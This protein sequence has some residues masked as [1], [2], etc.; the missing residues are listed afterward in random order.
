MLKKPHNTTDLYH[1]SRWTYQEWN[2]G[3]R[4]GQWC[5]SSCTSRPAQAITISSLWC[6][7]QILT[8][9][10]TSPQHYRITNLWYVT[11]SW[12]PSTLW[13]YGVTLQECNKCVQGFMLTAA[14]A[15]WVA[16]SC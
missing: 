8:V 3:D 4:S 13:R 15:G 10:W 14:G 9:H 7:S 2:E 11:W 12:V 5:M 6:N 1:F 16:H